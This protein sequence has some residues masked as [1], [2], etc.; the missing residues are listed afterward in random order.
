MRS[1]RYTVILS[2]IVFLLSGCQWFEAQ[3]GLVKAPEVKLAEPNVVEVAIAAEAEPAEA[4]TVRA[5]SEKTSGP[6]RP[7]TTP[8][9]CELIFKGE[10]GAAGDL[11]RQLRPVGPEF[12]RLAEIITEYEKI[13]EQQQS[14]QQA[15]FEE[16]L[17]KLEEFRLTAETSE[18]NDVNDVNNI[19]KILAVVARGCEF[20]NEQQKDE[21][22]S[23]AFVQRTFEKAK[24]RAAEFESEGKWID[25]YIVCYSWLA[26]IEKD[27]QAYLDYAK[28]LYEKAN[29]VATFVDSP[30]E[31]RRERYAGVKEQMFVRAIDTLNFNYVGPIDY[32][33]MATEAIR[34]CRL[35]G[36]VMSASFD[37]ISKTEAIESLE[38]GSLPRPDSEE[39]AAWSASLEAISVEVEQSVTGITKDKFIDVFERV[40]A[41][42][43][44][45]MQM[46]RRV[47]I[48]QFAEAS[49]SAL[50]PYTVMVWPKQ[51][52]DFEKSL[53]NKFT[54]IGI[55]IAKRSGLLTAESLLPDTPAYSSGLDA[56][57]VIEKVD[58]I[59][60]KDMTLSC[61]VKR[62]TGPAGTKV[63]LTVRGPGEDHT[64]DITITRAEITVPTIS[65]WQRS[66]QGKWIYMIN[67]ANKIGYVRI[68]TFADGTSSDLEKAL[69]GLE[70]KG[71]RGLILDLRF[72]S[73]GLLSSAIEVTDKFIKEGL[74]VSTRP[75]FG[76][77]TYAPARKTKS[78]FG[79]PLVILINSGSA[80]ASEIVSGALADKTH[81]RAILVGERTHGKS[82]VQT[83][84]HRPGGGAQL[85]YTMAYWYLPSGVRVPN[86]DEVKK[87]GR[88]D[89]GIAPDIE[90]KL[91]SSELK[92]MLD[93][94][95]NNQVLVKADHDNSARPVKRH[96]LE[97]SLE[98][99]PQMAVA[100]LAL[101]SK[102][103]EAG[104][105]VSGV[106]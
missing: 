62:I 31:T 103:I 73:G 66:E 49:L 8:Q 53:T 50:D 61:A 88:E 90:V 26:A 4:N 51:V 11:M 1:I 3:P 15:A 36:E 70:A 18:A 83:T 54:G 17:D 22:L 24:A 101:K 65:G 6:R 41:L 9:V 55:L 52:T 12:N 87:A 59:D 14:A 58:G 48:A 86:H 84:T 67:E 10:F 79:Y 7:V 104:F 95:R 38:E 102:L 28:E 21:L 20:A 94:Q 105:L 93:V 92:R 98:A 75:R 16:Q 100:L 23:D 13:D 69:A 63:I 47:L 76:V 57:D 74:I 40:L 5:V 35:L 44:V 78:H 60:T 43:E 25:A 96:T 80:S 34:R 106:N 82:S 46:P 42:N 56:G 64:R 30:C 27:N 99:D 97:E 45:I 32:A 89:W 2:V 68:T 37:E 81:E 29:I 77:S 72:N 33:E 39:V 91:T 71:L 85:K 19:P